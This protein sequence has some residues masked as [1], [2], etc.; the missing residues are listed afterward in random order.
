[1]FIGGVI[2][3]TLIDF[4]GRIACIVFT[5]GCTFRCPFCYN[6]DLVLGNVERLDEEAF[7]RWLESRRGKIEGVVVTG[8]EP[9]IQKDLPDFLERVKSM[10]F[11]TKLDTNGANPEMLEKILRQG[12]LDY[13][14][15]D[16]KA[17]F[18]AEK[19]S[20][21]TGVRNGVEEM[22]E[23][24]AES[25]GIIMSSGV[26]YEFRTTVVPTLHGEKEIRGIG[27]I[28]RGAK[29]WALQGFRPEPTLIDPEMRKVKPYPPKAMQRFAEIAKGYVERVELRGV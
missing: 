10:G 12:L 22:M 9:T 3:F 13:V 27:E 24:V 2:H 1:M 26:P 11:D 14:A 17:P 8:G 7:F 25:I 21:I 5:A 16:V 6:K 19:F 28:I 29:L 20:R 4:P 15:M 23:R 18:D